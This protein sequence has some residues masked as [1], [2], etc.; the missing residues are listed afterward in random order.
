MRKVDG[1]V[2][3]GSVSLDISLLYD[4]CRQGKW[5]DAI[6]LCRHQKSNNLW[7]VLASLSL[8]KKQLNIAENS[9]AEIN[10]VAKVEYVKR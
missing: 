5:E 6:R 3:F 9:L 4:L 8:S 1:S 2:I 10:E 7:A